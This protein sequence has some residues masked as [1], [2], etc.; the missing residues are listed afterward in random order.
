MC[1]IIGYTGPR[2]AAPILLDGLKKLEY[3]GYDSVGF[4][5]IGSNTIKIMKDIGRIDKVTSK[6][7][8]GALEGTTGISH[9]RWAT[10]GGVTK[11][12][13]HPHTS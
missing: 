10:T 13:A 7:D 4:A 2:Q 9:C 5:V 6:Y 12:N 1:G 11:P 8:L 3:R